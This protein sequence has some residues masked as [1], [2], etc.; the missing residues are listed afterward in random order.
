VQNENMSERK[1]QGS[2]NASGPPRAGAGLKKANL[3]E[4]RRFFF[5]AALEGDFIINSF[6]WTASMFAFTD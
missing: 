1:I 3:R 4:A 6:S 2:G 5:F